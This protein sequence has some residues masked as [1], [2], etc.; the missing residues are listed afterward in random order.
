MGARGDLSVWRAHNHLKAGLCV[1]AGPGAIEAVLAGDF[2]PRA[3]EP[4]CLLHTCSQA[5]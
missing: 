1:P 2:R 5:T 3:L 4:G